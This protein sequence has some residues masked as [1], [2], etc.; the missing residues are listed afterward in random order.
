VIAPYLTQMRRA[1]T[2]AGV[3]FIDPN[4]E[5]EGHRICDDGHAIWGIMFDGKARPTPWASRTRL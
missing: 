5:F 1:A 4:P 2:E 3:E